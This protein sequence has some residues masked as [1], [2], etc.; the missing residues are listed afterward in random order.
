MTIATNYRITGTVAHIPVRSLIET[1]GVTAWC[2]CGY[3]TPRL[4][5]WAAMRDLDRHCF[6]PTPQGP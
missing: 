3:R 2:A 1:D 5:V 6:A 4:P